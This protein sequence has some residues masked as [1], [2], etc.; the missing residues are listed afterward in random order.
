MN[1][2]QLA[3]PAAFVQFTPAPTA[4]RARIRFEQVID[5]GSPWALLIKW[6][7][8]SGATSDALIGHTDLDYLAV[9]AFGDLIEARRAELLNTAAPVVRI[10]GGVA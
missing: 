2:T 7:H 4:G 8:T 10:A 9:S 1:T 6:A 3:A 5:D